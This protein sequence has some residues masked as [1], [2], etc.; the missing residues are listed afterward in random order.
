MHT[1]GESCL[2]INPQ[3]AQVPRGTASPGR[4]T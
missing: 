2:P 4:M 3:R 1:A